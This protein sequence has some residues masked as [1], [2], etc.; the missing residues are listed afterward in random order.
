MIKLLEE[1]GALIKI[2]C[3]DGEEWEREVNFH[4]TVLITA[5]LAGVWGDVTAVK[6]RGWIERL[7]YNGSEAYFGFIC[8]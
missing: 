7:K 4:M 8:G 2:L 6:V 1:S 5:K 3:E